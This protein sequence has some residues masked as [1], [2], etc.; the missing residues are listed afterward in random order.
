MFCDVTLSVKDQNIMAHKNI[1][2]SHSEYLLRLFR[3]YPNQ[4]SF[5]ISLPDDVTPDTFK[6]VIDYIYTSQLPIK[7]SNLM[8]MY[9]IHNTVTYIHF[10]ICI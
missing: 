7:E 8:V 1:L 5:K 4:E 9:I 10:I 3:E 6:Q 2:A